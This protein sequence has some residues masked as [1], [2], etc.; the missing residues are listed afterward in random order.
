MILFYLEIAGIV[1]G[2]TGLFLLS[3]LE[4]ALLAASP[5]TLR[6]SLEREDEKTPPLLELVIENKSHLFLPL[7]LGIQV[8]LIIVAILITHVSMKR[9]PV[10][11][12]DKRE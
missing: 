4:G 2:A 9:W 1:A 6:M 8:A 10:W 7:H 5:V 11:G 12:L 3:M